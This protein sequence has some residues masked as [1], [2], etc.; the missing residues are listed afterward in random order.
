VQGYCVRAVKDSKG[1]EL[2]LDGRT[3][4][5]ERTKSPEISWLEFYWCIFIFLNLYP[6]EL[7]NGELPA[8]DPLFS[9]SEPGDLAVGT[10]GLCRDITNTPEGWFS[11]RLEAPEKVS[12]WQISIPM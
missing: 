2:P 9:L 5:L 10:V 12:Q 3:N 4:F 6:T 11:T 8:L 7:E 1:Q